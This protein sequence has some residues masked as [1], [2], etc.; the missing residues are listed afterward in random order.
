M[1][2]PDVLAVMRASAKRERLDE[3]SH[4]AACMEEARAA[5]AEAFAERDRLRNIVRRREAQI[6]RMTAERA[7]LIEAARLMADLMPD[8]ELETDPVQ[9]EIVARLR[10]ALARCGGAK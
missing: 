8:A 5:V 2:A 9:G 6:L 4:H 7:E 3:N 1:N 10:A